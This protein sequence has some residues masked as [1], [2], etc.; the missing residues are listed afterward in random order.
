MVQSTP[1]CLHSAVRMRYPCVRRDFQDEVRARADADRAGVLPASPSV[2]ARS[3]DPRFANARNVSVRPYTEQAS[4]DL[5]V[6]CS[7][8]KTFDRWLRR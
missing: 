7:G 8:V 2:T 3:S 4:P 1:L 6:S 5:Q